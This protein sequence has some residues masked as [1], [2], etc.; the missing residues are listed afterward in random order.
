MPNRQFSRFEIDSLDD[1]KE[2][3]RA[4]GDLV[5]RVVHGIDLTAVP[6]L[7]GSDL[8][9][10]VLLGCKFTSAKQRRGLE[11]RGAIVFPA[12]PDLPYSPYRHELYTVAELFDG[13]DDGGYVATRDFAIYTHFDRARRA[14]GGVRLKESLAQRLHDHAIDDALYEFVDAHGGRRVVGI[15]GGHGT[16]RDD[17]DFAAVVRLCRELTR[18]GF[19][20]ATGGGPGIMEA[21]NLGAF[22]ANFEDDAVVEAAIDVLS[23]APQFADGQQE[24]TPEYL[25]AIRRYIAAATDARQRLESDEWAQRYSRTSAT[26][27]ASLAVPTWFYGHEPTNL[28]CDHV[29][30]YF[31]NGLREDVLLAVARGGVVFAPGSAGTLQEIF[32]DLAQ[33]HYAT[34]VDRSPMVFLG[35]ERYAEIHDVIRGFID[36]RAMTQTYGDLVAA[37]DDPIE[38]ADFIE[39]HPPRARQERAPLYELV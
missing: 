22:L 8:D 34:F 19:L 24:G 35:R 13:Y 27:P 23:Q 2:H 15:M 25:Q 29:A 10:C 12:L 33:N 32:M 17:P 16:S 28:F 1:L 6:G 3:L 30:K 5:D 9:G 38:I 36:R 11:D 18:R 37:F 39:S 21:G 26:A 20:V 14:A 7:G 4:G 31:A